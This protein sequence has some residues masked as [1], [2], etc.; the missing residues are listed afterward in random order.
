MLSA[1]V[2]QLREDLK[3]CQQENRELKRRLADQM[4]IADEARALQ[5]GTKEN[6]D[7]L[8]L[9]YERVKG[10]RDQYQQ[11]LENMTI[12]YQRSTQELK[13]RVAELESAQ[14]KKFNDMISLQTENEILRTKVKNL[15]AEI[16][17]YKQ[18]NVDSANIELEKAQQ[19]IT[20]LQQRVIGLSQDIN[21]QKVAYGETIEN[22]KTTIA[23][24]HEELF[25]EDGGSDVTKLPRA[26]LE[27]KIVQIHDENQGLQAKVQE[28]ERRV[29][30]AESARP[31]AR[32]PESAVDAILRNYGASQ[33]LIARSSRDPADEDLEKIIQQGQ[34]G[35][36]TE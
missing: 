3:Q 10:E 11:Q 17:K 9:Q 34:S 1:D 24:L 5:E 36:A 16:A 19:L 7:T 27:Q 13:S 31:C 2:Q 23:A 20:Q 29:S 26:I 21:K 18:Q 12:K 14:E 35:R 33:Q 28:L 4:Q 22:L 6:L 15:N 25:E 32:R 30:E 8:N